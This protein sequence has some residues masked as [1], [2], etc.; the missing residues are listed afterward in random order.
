MITDQCTQDQESVSLWRRLEQSGCASSH[1]LPTCTLECLL[2]GWLDPPPP[3][4]EGDPAV[5]GLMLSAA[6]EKLGHREGALDALFRAK[7]RVPNDARVRLSLAKLLFRAGRKEES[8]E[9]LGFI[10]D[11]SRGSCTHPLPT[12]T[13]AILHDAWYLSGWVSIHG[14]DHTTAYATWGEGALLAPTDE[15][16][17][18][19]KRKV[20]VWATLLPSET[21][22]PTLVGEGGHV[23]DREADTTPFHLPASHPHE[24]AASLLPKD[25]GGALVYTSKQA[26]LTP[27]ECKAVLACVESHVAGALGGVWGTVRR[28]SVLTTDIA[29]E[30]VPALIPWLRALLVS[31]IF[32]MLAVCFPALA[33][34]GSLGEGGERLRVHDA[35]IVRYDHA[36]GSTS[37]PFHHDTSAFSVSLPLTQ[38]GRDYEGGGL[39]VAALKDAPCGGVVHADA[40]AATV[41]TGPL[42]HGGQEITSGLRVILVLFLY[43]EG[44]PYG[45]LLGHTKKSGGGEREA[46]Q[47]HSDRAFVV[48]RETTQLAEAL[49]TGVDSFI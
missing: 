1:P 33:D 16:L 14:D 25:H 48:Y 15:R 23:R 28:S 9:E 41:F 40:G 11:A 34:G 47:A 49:V 35:F 39:T 17:Q 4:P 42:K 44:W 30:E 13:P 32:P 21:S 29:V 10:L 3:G 22:C 43:V 26:L 27:K 36:H 37:L 7:G 20:D 45:H 31:R 12:L 18:R 24:P 8:Q 46:K 2:E 6:L 5:V 19:Q 38:V